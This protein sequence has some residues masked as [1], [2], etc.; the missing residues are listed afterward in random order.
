MDY[1]LYFKTLL[2]LFDESEFVE[3]HLNNQIYRATALAILMEDTSLH[4]R[5]VRRIT[6]NFNN[7]VVYL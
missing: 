3:V 4:S 6:R 5:I 2:M 1:K 7:I